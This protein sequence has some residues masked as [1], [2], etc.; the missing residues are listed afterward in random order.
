MLKWLGK[1]FGSDTAVAAAR[2]NP[3]FLAAV[4]TSAQ[5]FHELPEKVHLDETAR[6]R[7][8]RQLYLELHEA[9]NAT[10]P[11]AGLRQKIAEA[12]L[13]HALFQVLIV[14]P[15][16]EPDASGLRGLPGITGALMQRLDDVARFNSELHAALYEDSNDNPGLPVEVLL[17]RAHAASAWRVRSFDAVR[18][19]LG[20]VTRGRDDWYR[21]FL[22]AACANQESRY[23][24]DLDMPSAFEPGLAATA[25]VA[26]SLFTD[27]VLSGAKD[28]LAEWIDYHCDAGIPMPRFDEAPEL[29]DRS[30]A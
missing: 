3:A 21:P 1:V 2:R 10:S 14:P 7:Q 22:F 23:R 30:A 8:A 17:R 27:I 29:P 6:R 5:V 24:R 20:D 13:Q 16:P 28:P 9:F 15:A 18:R 25:P 12:M 19:E 26:Y 11:V 4:D